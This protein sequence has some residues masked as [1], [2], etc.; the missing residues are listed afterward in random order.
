MGGAHG[1]HGLDGSEERLFVAFASSEELCDAFERELAHGALFVPTLAAL[2]AGRQVKVTLLFKFCGAQLDLDGEVVTALP[3]DITHTG[4]TPGLSV[5]MAEPL[6]RFRERIEANTG[7][8]LPDPEPA[9]CHSERRQPRFP[10]RSSVEMVVAGR[11]FS[12]ETVD[13]SYNGL[14]AL[15]SGVDLGEGTELSVLIS[16]PGGGETLSLDAK[17]AN[18]TPCDHGVMAVGIQ[19]MYDLSRVDEVAAFVDDLRGFQHARSLATVTGSVKDA[20]L[21]TLL[22]TFSASASS[23]TLRLTQG[24]ET[25]KLVYQEN[26]I[27][28]ASTGLVSGVKALGRMFTW[29][30]A[31]F[32][33]E[34]R[35][36]PLDGDEA[37]FPLQSAIL[38]AAVERDELARI[39]LDKLDADAS[40]VVDEERLAAVE[41][42]LDELGRELAENAGLGFPLGALIDILTAS[43]AR[44]YKALAELIEAGVL[45]VEPA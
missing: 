15:I 3:P 14:L 12:A 9:V 44:I 10:A 4:A 5:Q 23:G 35:I 21:E 8:S 19:F 28:H 24:A 36:E 40:F 32:E 16:H 43:D 13:V 25:G 11:K 1:M 33:F 27:L 39:D 29:T 30:E 45:R 6:D 20:P 22:E 7:V 18:Q 41:S 34:P 26:E 31:Q 38:S 17:I 42:T 37:R 2:P